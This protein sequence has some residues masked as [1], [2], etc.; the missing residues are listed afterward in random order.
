[1]KELDDLLLEYAHRP[2]YK[3]E[4]KSEI[5]A[6]FTKKIEGIEEVLRQY[7]VHYSCED[8]W[9]SCPQSTGGCCNDSV[10]DECNC[11]LDNKI[12]KIIE[13]SKVKLLGG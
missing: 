6:L 3:G 4:L 2:Y 5:I 1:M 11:G 12:N 13:A 10:G 9:Y 8:C 7:M